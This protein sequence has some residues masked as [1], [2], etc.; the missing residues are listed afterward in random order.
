MKK[1]LLLFA[2]AFFMASCQTNV[3]EDRYTS[4][5]CAQTQACLNFAIRHCEKIGKK[6]ANVLYST[7]RERESGDGFIGSRYR[8]FYKASYQCR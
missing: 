5:E 2:A 8:R 3:Y 7:Y 4:L 6:P 1:F